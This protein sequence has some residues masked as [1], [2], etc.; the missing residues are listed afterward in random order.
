MDFSLTDEHNLIRESAAKFAKNEIVPD[1]RERD[2]E[3]KS[4]RKVLEKMAEAG[5]I[6]KPAGRAGVTVRATSSEARTART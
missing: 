1:L 2:R 6:E 3:A 5:M 4:D